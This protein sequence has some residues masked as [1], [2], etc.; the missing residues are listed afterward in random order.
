MIDHDA[1]QRQA[2]A[3][4][5][6]CVVGALI[7]DARGL[8]FVHRR[9]PDRAFLAGGWDLVGGHVEAGE[10][11]LEA[12][13][14]EVAEE[15]GWRLVGSPQLVFVGDWWTDRADPTTARREFD[16]LVNVEG[17]LGRPRLERPKHVE[18]RWIGPDKLDLLDENAGR[19]DGMVRHLV[20]LALR[21]VRG[22]RGIAYPHATLFVGGVSAEP[23]ERIRRR[24]DPGLAGQIAAHVT[25]AYPDEA[26]SLEQL[27]V[28][29]RAAAARTEPVRLR[30]GRA[31][32]TPDAVPWVGIEVADFEGGWRR[33]RE[34]IAPESAGRP[35]VTPHI[36]VVHPRHSTLGAQAWEE[37]VLWPGGTFTARELAITAF[38]GSV[39]RTIDG[40]PLEADPG[41]AETGTVRG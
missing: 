6:R 29:A 21:S 22:R 9:G 25:V 4:G 33:L 41:L 12:L 16:F 39:W 24:W 28:R 1:L 15:S 31:M 38:D 27:V 19:D 18:H 8:A 14:R 3:D 17:D 30:M 2:A 11:L 23:I 10:T 34:L 26:A 7:L 13:E 20:G 37:I 32:R 5:R 35:D 36:T 40:F